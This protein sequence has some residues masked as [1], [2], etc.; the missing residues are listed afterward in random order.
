MMKYKT[1][2]EW[3]KAFECHIIS[4]M[5]TY[6]EILGEHYNRRALLF[7]DYLS[8]LLRWLE[9]KDEPFKQALINVINDE[10]LYNFTGNEY[11]FFLIYNT[12]LFNLTMCKLWNDNAPYPQDKWLLKAQ[13]Q[14][15]KNIKNKKIDFTPDSPHNH[16]VFFKARCDELLSNFDFNTL[17]TT[18]RDKVQAKNIIID[19]LIDLILSD[20]YARIKGRHAPKKSNIRVSSKS[21]EF[22]QLENEI[23]K[24]KIK[25][26]RNKEPIDE[27]ATLKECIEFM[28]SENH[29]KAKQYYKIIPRSKMG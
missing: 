2:N 29:V 9:K 8:D 16:I 4:K 21:E 19:N 28:N 13:R 12:V 14:N 27:N 6:D 7:C 26:K 25:N 3:C 11:H 5:I 18:R 10:H 17:Y 20:N 22:M 24:L 23:E 15:E 1:L